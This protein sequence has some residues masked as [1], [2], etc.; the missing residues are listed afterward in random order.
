[1]KSHIEGLGELQIL[2]KMRD[3]GGGNDKEPTARSWRDFPE[4]DEESLQD[5]VGEAVADGSVLNDTLD[6]IDEN[7]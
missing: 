7:D 2:Q 4:Q 3:G 1:M 5:L 6:V